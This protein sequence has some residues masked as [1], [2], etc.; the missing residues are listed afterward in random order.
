MIT[1]FSA[2]SPTQCVRRPVDQQSRGTNI[3]DQQ[4]KYP[5]FS[6]WTPKKTHPISCSIPAYKNSFETDQHL[7]N[8]KHL[9]A[10]ADKQASR[11]AELS[12]YSWTWVVMGKGKGAKLRV[13]VVHAE[14]RLVSISFLAYCN[15]STQRMNVIALTQ[16]HSNS[17]KC[18][19]GADGALCRCRENRCD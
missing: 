10:M 4:T 19:Q 14:Y 1:K 8:V 12:S 9:I 16:Y 15:D 11:G 13:H 6:R 17:T 18:E 5:S 2:N 7:L 3:R